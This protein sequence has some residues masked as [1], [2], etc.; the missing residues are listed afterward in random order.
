MAALLKFFEKLFKIK[1]VW[2]FFAAGHG[3]GCVDGIGAVVK[4]KVRR[5]INSR[6]AI[7][8]NSHD[9][10][11][12]FNAEESTIKVID[13]PKIAADKI[14]SELKLNEIF[15]NAKDVKGIFSFHQL[16]VVNDKI[17]GF[18]TSQDGYVSL[19]G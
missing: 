19:K 10:V 8:Y 15:D 12:A 11:K 1:I 9:F 17:V 3:K 14:R 2:N 5:L 18:E 6:K 16:Q 13:M 7:V 4:N